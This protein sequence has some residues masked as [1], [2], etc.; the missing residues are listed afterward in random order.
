MQVQGSASVSNSVISGSA[1][2][3]SFVDPLFIISPNYASTYSLE[4]SPGVQNGV[5]AG[6]PEPSTWA[7]MLLGFAGVFAFRLTRRKVSFA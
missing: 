6:V 7:M 4:F 5:V 1:S 2:F 3:T